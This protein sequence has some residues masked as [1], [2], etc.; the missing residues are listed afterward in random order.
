MKKIFFLVF[1]ILFQSCSFDNRLGIWQNINVDVKEKHQ[2][3]GLKSLLLSDKQFD[4]II[5][6]NSKYKFDLPEG[7]VEQEYISVCNSLNKNKTETK[8]DKKENNIK[9]DEKMTKD[10]K[11]DAK[12]IAQRRV[13]LGLLM[14]DIGRN[15]NIDVSEEEIKQA[16]MMEA[17]KYPGQ[18]KQVLE[19]YEKNKEAS[20][21]LA[22][23]LFEE[24]VFD[25]IC[26]MSE[27]K[28]KTVSVED[29]Y[30][31]EGEGKK[32]LTKKQK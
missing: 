17:Q 20:Q 4:E 29:L 12:N 6:F 21:N 16:V 10:E 7:M 11:V 8:N 22:G 24:K 9:P 30:K 19:Y 5:P 13:K 18:E 15:N 32:K 2:L 27:I 28:E 26:E 31:E 23:P 1:L 25:F 3:K 14:G